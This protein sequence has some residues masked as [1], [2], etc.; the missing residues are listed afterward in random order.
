[1]LTVNHADAGYDPVTP[2]IQCPDLAAAIH[3]LQC[4]VAKWF[5]PEVDGELLT[6][7]EVQSFCKRA[8]ELQAKSR[9]VIRGHIFWIQ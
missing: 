3:A 1:M 4:E 9:L 7:R 5:L 2:D 8:M 6:N